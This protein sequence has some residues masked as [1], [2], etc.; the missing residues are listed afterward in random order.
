MLSNSGV[1]TYFCE[2]QI[3]GEFQRRLLSVFTRLASSLSVGLVDSAALGHRF[4]AHHW[5]AA[6]PTDLV[7]RS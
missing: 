7:A 2:T 6:T 3:S 5:H 4:E 1:Q